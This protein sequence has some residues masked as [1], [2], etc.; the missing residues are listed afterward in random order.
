MLHLFSVNDAQQL[1]HD[2]A[3]SGFLSKLPL[4]IRMII[5]EMVLGEAMAAS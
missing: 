5:Y 2:Q 4:D 1:C 3:D